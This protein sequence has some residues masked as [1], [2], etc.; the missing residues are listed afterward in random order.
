[1]TGAVRWATL[2]A[3]CVAACSR[4]APSP[5]AAPTTT[6]ATAAD[7]ATPPAPAVL[8]PE[9]KVKLDSGNVLFRAKKYDAA[10]AQYRAAAALAPKHTAP[11]YGISMVGRAMNNQKLAD[12]ATAEM[13]KL[14]GPLPAQHPS[15]SDSAVR[16]AH[17]QAAKSKA[18]P[19][20]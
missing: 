11:L 8:G 3:L 1:M 16:D 20:G 15:L 7:S 5:N 17:K 4:G 19:T 9:A 18:N 2:V 12:S 13:Q 10:L 6:A 14:T